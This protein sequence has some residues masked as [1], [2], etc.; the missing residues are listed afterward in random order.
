[1]ADIDIEVLPVGFDFVGGLGNDAITEAVPGTL[2]I[3]AGMK[4]RPL[5]SAGE[6][7][8]LGNKGLLIEAEMS[9][10]RLDA[11]LT[12]FATGSFIATRV[13][14]ALPKL[15]SSGTVEVPIGARS[16]AK[17]FKVM[18]AGEIQVPTGVRTTAVLPALQS[19]GI[20]I[21]PPIQAKAASKLPSL[22]MQAEVKVPT[23]MRA[24]MRL[25]ALQTQAS[26]SFRNN[27]HANAYLPALQLASR[28]LIPNNVT[29]SGVLPSLS[30]KGSMLTTREMKL[31]AG[32]QLPTL[33]SAGRID[34]KRIMLSGSATLPMLMLNGTLAIKKPPS[35]GRR[36]RNGLPFIGIG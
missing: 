3:T 17:L 5:Q 34:F 7:V 36:R 31:L 33:Q 25:P 12:E 2:T 19:R 11:G 13:A 8:V 18:S 6:F 24:S 16:R 30:F 22:V 20:F 27:M 15:A 1:M 32:M 26:I 28:L 21:I 4:L 9:V 14:G 29:V 23:G 10:F 35:N